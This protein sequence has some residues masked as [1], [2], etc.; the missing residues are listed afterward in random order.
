M[1][2]KKK[3]GTI[4]LIDLGDGYHAYARELHHPFVA[5]YDTRTIEPMEPDQIIS[6]PF[7]FILAVFDKAFIRWQ[8]VGYVPLIPNEL[9]VPDRF[10]QDVVNPGDCRIVDV[11]GWE[12]PATIEECIGLEAAAIWDSDEVEDRIRDHYAGRK[13]VWLES[14][15]VKLLD[16]DTKD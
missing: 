2:R 9:A 5:I 1:A 15:K 12:H 6:Q 14:L 8:K 11:D 4:V 13:N 7:L 3:P 10:I 16:K